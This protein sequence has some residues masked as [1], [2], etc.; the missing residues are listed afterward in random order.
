MVYDLSIKFAM[1]SNKGN[2]NSGVGMGG[3]EDVSYCCPSEG[4]AVEGDE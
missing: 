3:P 2:I 4:S 1:D